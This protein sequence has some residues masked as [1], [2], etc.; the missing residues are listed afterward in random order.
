MIDE[1]VTE[2]LRRQRDGRAFQMDEDET[3]ARHQAAALVQ[4]VLDA[5]REPSEEMVRR[6]AQLLGYPDHDAAGM[7][8][9]RYLFSV[10]IK[11]AR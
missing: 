2:I 4:V 1:I 5:L 7:V 6:G 8:K 10:M 9:A 3:F 11:G